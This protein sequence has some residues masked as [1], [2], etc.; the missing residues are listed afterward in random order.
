MA[1]FQSF[2]LGLAVYF[3]STL[4]SSDANN[5]LLDGLEIGY[6]LFEVSYNIIFEGSNLTLRFCFRIVLSV[7]LITLCQILM[8]DLSKIKRAN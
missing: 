5:R 1:C 8:I 3:M 6:G 2:L 7:H 4:G